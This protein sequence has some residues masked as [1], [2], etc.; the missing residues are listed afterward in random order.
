MPPIDPAVRAEV[1]ALPV[2][3]AHAELAR[4]DP[5]AAA[6]LHANDTTRV[7]RA[8]E[9]VRS[10]GRRL[11]A[12]QE[13]RGGG[14]G[15]SIDL[16]AVVLL[17]PREAL[18]EAIDR[19]A[20]AMLDAGAVEEAAALLARAD[21]PPDAPIRR[22]IGVEAVAAL[23]RGEADRAATEA[24]LALDTRRYAKRQ[25]TWLRHQASTDW[26]RLD[27]YSSRLAIHVIKLL[28]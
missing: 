25:F 7:A 19:R 12:W 27:D 17:P 14:I 10:T 16:A 28:C 11:A 6:R 18:Y 1:R 2:A 21:V 5:P 20:G 23:L 9:V 13:A 4:L 24:R 3:I 8:L 15:D 26:I 22:A